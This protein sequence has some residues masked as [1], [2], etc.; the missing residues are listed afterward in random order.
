MLYLIKDN[1]FILL[2]SYSHIFRFYSFVYNFLPGPTFS[3]ILDA[4]LNFLGTIFT[5]TW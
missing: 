3:S 1:Y 5:P 4:I 2:V